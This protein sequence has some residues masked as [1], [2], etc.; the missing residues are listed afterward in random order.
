MYRAGIETSRS[1]VIAREQPRQPEAIQNIFD[2]L[3][4]MNCHENQRFSRNDTWWIATAL[5]RLAMTPDWLCW[6]LAQTFTPA[7]TE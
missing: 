7:M 6:L 4:K 5:T 2:N 1:A 3:I